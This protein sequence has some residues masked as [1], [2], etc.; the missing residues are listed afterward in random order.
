MYFFQ[1]QIG[2][3]ND[4]NT[5]GASYPRQPKYTA[6]NYGPEYTKRVVGG[7]NHQNGSDDTA[8]SISHH[9]IP[10]NNQVRYA[11]TNEENIE[12]EPTV[13]IE[14]LGPM[15][16]P[17]HVDNSINS[18]PSLQIE[19]H[20]FEDY[21]TPFTVQSDN[22]PLVATQHHKNGANG[23]NSTSMQVNGKIKATK[24]GVITSSV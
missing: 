17:N 22:K 8:V 1:D 9:P 14:H 7:R 12:N 20:K 18:E 13:V 15:K 19:H 4:F 23:I 24:N 2:E 21:K 11:S 6:P 3:N 16:R 5:T 10:Q